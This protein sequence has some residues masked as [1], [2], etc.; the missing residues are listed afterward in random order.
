MLYRPAG[1]DGLSTLTSSSKVSGR[2]FANVVTFSEGKIELELLRV[3]KYIWKTERLLYSESNE[4]RKE[5]KEGVASLLIAGM[6]GASP[7]IA[8]REF[9][10]RGNPKTLEPEEIVVIK[11]I[12]CPSITC[13]P[14]SI[15]F[16][17]KTEE[18]QAFRKEHRR[19]YEVLSPV[20]GVRFMVTYQAM[21][22]SD[23]GSPIDIALVTSRGVQWIEQKPE[24]KEPQ[25]RT[26][27]KR[28]DSKQASKSGKP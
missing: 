5:K 28:Q 18:I 14:P 20:D 11:R 10:V 24:C 23:V 6:S 8:F 17:G 12:D 16:V 1:F 9:D 26:L 13:E 27:R 15:V 25:N 21:V 2:S 3:L 19:T 4:S 7:M 22:R